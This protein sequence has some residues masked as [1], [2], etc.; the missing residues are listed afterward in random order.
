MFKNVKSVFFTKIVFSIINDKR[1]LEIVKYNKQ[2]QNVIDIELNN[3]KLFSGKYLIF[4]E[5]GKGKEYSLINNDLIFEGEYINGK[6][7]GKG[8][9]YKY[10]KLIFEGEYLNGK[11]HGNGKE[12]DFFYEEKIF[13]GEYKNG[14]KWNGKI[15]F[16]D[17]FSYELKDGKGIVKNYYYR[18]EMLSFEGGYIN[19]EFNG[20]CKEYFDEDEDDDD[21][22]EKLLFEGEYK[23]GKKW[24][25][26]GYDI[27]GNIIYELKNGKGYI[28]E[29][30]QKH[31][32]LYLKCEGNLLNG[33][34]NGLWK[35]YQEG[36]LKFEGEYKDNKINGKGKEFNLKTGELRFE[37]E[38]LYDFKIK[39]KE[40]IE[41]R[42]EYEGEY[43][44]NKKWNGKGYDE[45]GNIIYILKNGRGKF[46]DY[47]NSGELIFD[48][49]YLN[50][51][52]NGM[53]KEY[54]NGKLIFDGEY[55]NGEKH[56]KIKEYWNGKLTFDGEYL[57]GKKHGMIKE[58][59]DGKLTFDGEYLNGE[60]HGMIK[61]YYDNGKL[62]FGRKVFK[63][64][65]TW[66]WKGI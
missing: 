31:N 50:G 33:E 36:K 52:K 12:Y 25:G 63:R 14:K 24:S 59:W 41:G 11:K 45:N 23:N 29:Y 46:K 30:E 51:K 17:K 49:E 47:N 35:N 38:Y 48:G 40:Y 60:K 66:I 44:W 18:S 5:N 53:M 62:K 21:V 3:Y 26:K 10:G 6:K 9:E 22:D 58:Y 7:N 1:K 28:K 39:G 2:L 4:E 61:E 64:E 57:N 55:L 43:F 56:G 16:L 8:K 54:C 34:K 19:G 13:E 15:F 20:K 27:N 37:G 32:K 42:L 65:E